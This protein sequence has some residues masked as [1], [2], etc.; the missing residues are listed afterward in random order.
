MGCA[1]AAL[2]GTGVGTI[3][4]FFLIGFAFGTCALE[5]AV[6]RRCLAKATKHDEIRV[7]ALSKLNTVHSHNSKALEDCSISDE[8]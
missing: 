5:V 3:P 1:G 7:L 8:E 6:R 4:G 2:A